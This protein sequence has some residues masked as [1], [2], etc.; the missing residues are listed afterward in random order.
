[1]KFFALCLVFVSA[2]LSTSVFAHSGHDHSHP[3]SGFVHLVWLL[4][5]VVAAFFGIK[6]VLKELELNIKS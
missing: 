2:I 3:M 6:F 4:P 1:M 5:L